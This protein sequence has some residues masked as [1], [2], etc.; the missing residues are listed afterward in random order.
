MSCG[1]SVRA[2]LPGRLHTQRPVLRG[3][4]RNGA[5][6]RV[7]AHELFLHFTGGWKLRELRAMSA[8]EPLNPTNARG[9]KQGTELTQAMS[10]EETAGAVIGRYHLLQT[11]GEG[12]MGEAWL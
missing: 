5:L 6:S 9:P 2:L 12:G 11:I 3:K 10:P 7:P 4:R 1:P 8:E